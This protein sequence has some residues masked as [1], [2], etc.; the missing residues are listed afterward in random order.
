MGEVE[1]QDIIVSVARC[2]VSIKH[3]GV[4]EAS[5]P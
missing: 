2:L 4:G 5:L 3:K 1:T